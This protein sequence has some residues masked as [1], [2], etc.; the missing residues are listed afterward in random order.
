MVRAGEVF[1]ALC[2]NG[3]VFSVILDGIEYI[4]RE[5]R[6]NDSSKLLSSDAS[7]R[8]TNLNHLIE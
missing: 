7:G 4:L 6:S 3:V 2:G 1:V 5:K 8:L